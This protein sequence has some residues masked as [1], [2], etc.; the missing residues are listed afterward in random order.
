MGDLPVDTNL[1][2]QGCNTYIKLHLNLIVIKL[3]EKVYNGT[4]DKRQ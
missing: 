4:F 2:T 3:D 1:S